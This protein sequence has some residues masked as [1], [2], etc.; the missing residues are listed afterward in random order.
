MLQ[1]LGVE[2]AP[3]MSPQESRKFLE[4]E[5]TRLGSVIQGANIKPE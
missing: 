1:K 2:A 5:L 3:T 4:S